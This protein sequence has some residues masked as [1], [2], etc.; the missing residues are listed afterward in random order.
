MYRQAMK[1]PQLGPARVQIHS[2]VEVPLTVDDLTLRDDTDRR[3]YFAPDKVTITYV[4]EYAEAGTVDETIGPWD[5]TAVVS[6]LLITG[7]AVG[8]RRSSRTFTAPPGEMDPGLP[9]WLG[10]IIG[11]Y[12]PAKRA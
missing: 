11:R 1:T 9:D 3:R 6:G 7:G 4:Q 12:H 10:D 5:V 2:I 8:K